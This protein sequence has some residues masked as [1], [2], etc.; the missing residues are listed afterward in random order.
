M[1]VAAVIQETIEYKAVPQAQFS[2]TV[3]GR[4]TIGNIKL[5]PDTITVVG[6]TIRIQ[7]LTEIQTDPINLEGRKESF[8]EKVPITLPPGLQGY[9]EQVEL[10]VEIIGE[11]VPEQLSPGTDQE[12]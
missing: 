6:N 10:S 7:P 5:E 9:P 1:Q 8:V 3:G 11:S 4:L 12:E 2:G